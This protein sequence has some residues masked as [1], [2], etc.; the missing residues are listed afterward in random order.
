MPSFPPQ[1]T[2]NPFSQSTAFVNVFVTKRAIFSAS[3]KRKW[4]FRIFFDLIICTSTT[5]ALLRTNLCP[6]QSVIHSVSS[7][8]PFL[9]NTHILL[10]QDKIFRRYNTY[11]QCGPKTC[12]S[13]CIS[14]AYP[15]IRQKVSLFFQIHFHPL[16][17]PSSNFLSTPRAENGFV[18]VYKFSVE[19]PSATRTPTEGAILRNE[20]NQH[21]IPHSSTP[22]IYFMP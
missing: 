17:L 12:N 8:T 15:A 20:R 9:G 14:I 6:N 18:F 7:L 19:F 1:K 11:S 4:H 13:D 3:Q 5:K 2:V 10:D 22:K 16:F 21:I